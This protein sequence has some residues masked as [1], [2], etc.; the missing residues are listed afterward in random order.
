MCLVC[1]RSYSLLWL[2]FTCEIRTGPS[3]PRQIG[4]NLT[5]DMGVPDIRFARKTWASPEHIGISW[6]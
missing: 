3:S 6:L 4:K 2:T 5:V 1:F